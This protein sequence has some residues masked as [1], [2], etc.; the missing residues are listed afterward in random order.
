MK[1]F[2][3]IFCLLT[4]SLTASAEANLLAE[5]NRRTEQN[6]IQSIYNIVNFVGRLPRVSQLP[7]EGIPTVLPK[8]SEYL[9]LVPLRNNDLCGIKEE[10]T[11]LGSRAFSI[12]CFDK[13]GREI[14]REY[15]NEAKKSTFEFRK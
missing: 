11:T 5:F 15:S 13:N 1:K 6:Y 4:T 3:A 2:A 12:V 9:A 10:I 7:F 14:F 8:G